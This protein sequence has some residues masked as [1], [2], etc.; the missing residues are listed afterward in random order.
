MVSA[1]IP[2]LHQSVERAHANTVH[3][4]RECVNPGMGYLRQG[5]AGSNH[6]SHRGMGQGIVEVLVRQ[7]RLGCVSFL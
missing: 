7:E 5:Q 6:R 1:G 2:Q 3:F 4:Q